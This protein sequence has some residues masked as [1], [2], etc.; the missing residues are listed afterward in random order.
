MKNVNLNR[1]VVNV[2]VGV[3][4]GCLRV[5][6]RHRKSCHHRPRPS[7]SPR[8]IERLCLDFRITPRQATQTIWRAIDVVPMG[9]VQIEN[10]G[11]VPF[12]VHIQLRHGNAVQQTIPPRSAFALTTRG[13]EQISVSGTDENGNNPCVGRV[14]I[15]LRVVPL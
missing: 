6:H 11:A 5:K 9:S 15:L 12:D 14:R 3:G 7:K 10:R 2:R 4:V 13:I 8:W 1:Q